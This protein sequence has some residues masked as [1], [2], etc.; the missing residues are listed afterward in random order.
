M[1]WFRLQYGYTPVAVSKMQ[2]RQRGNILSFVTV[3][4]F[5]ERIKTLNMYINASP[6]VYDS[7]FS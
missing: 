4:L 5:P 1:W 7:M 3:A 2:Y 6:L